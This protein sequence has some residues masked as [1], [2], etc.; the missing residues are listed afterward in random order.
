MAPEA[1]IPVYLA[2]NTELKL[3]GATNVALNLSSFCDIEFISVIGND[4]DI[5]EI[6]KIFDKN[7]IK[8]N[9]FKEN[10]KSII[11]NRIIC[12]NLIST[13][14]DIEDT[15]DINKNTQNNIY[16]HILSKI[17]NLD[18]II[19]SDYNKGIIPTELC[20]NIISLANLNNVSIFI[21][22]KV[23][24]IDKYKN[25]TF[26]KPNMK[27]AIELLN[28]NSI[29]NK[30]EIIKKLFSKIN[31][32]YLLVTDN[33]NGM[34][35]Y[36]HNNLINV[37][38]ENNIKVI[39]VTGAGD[40]V[41]SVFVYI[42]L[43]TND[44]IYAIN[45]SNYIA[46]KS[47]QHLGN[48]RFRIEDIKEYNKIIYSHQ[49]DILKNISKIHKNIVFTNG[50]FDIIHIGHLKLLNYCKTLGDILVLGINSDS[51]IKKLKGENRPI[52]CIE[53]RVKFLDL[54][55]IVDYIVIFDELTPIE[56]LKNLKPTFL[57][58]GGDYTVENV[59]G[60]EYVNKVIICDLVPDKST[61][62]I[63]KKIN[64]NI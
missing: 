55:N 13:R 20:K 33:E 7:N 36:E 22:P 57:V 32:K 37:K 48:Y 50:C 9:F 29:I 47:V 23:N 58:K 8:Y 21:D 62:N 19:I 41:I 46:G 4:I 25:C 61:T 53:D 11:K 59:I 17:N 18:G 6:E 64:F 5:S 26:F 14:F 51:S 34:I 60:K 38:H 10:R 56:I 30:E 39:D 3:G 63:I 54:L 49:S 24:N 44:F 28:D 1:N 52:N 40:T 27:E 31:C 45:I 15:F 2:S 12:N 43:L 42:Y 16:E 35:G